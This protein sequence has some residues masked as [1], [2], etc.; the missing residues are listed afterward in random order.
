MKGL[1][2]ANWV[3]CVLRLASYV[4]L[5]VGCFWVVGKFGEMLS[6]KDAIDAEAAKA[7]AVIL[8]LLGTMTLGFVFS[9]VC[10]VL[11]IVFGGLSLLYGINLIMYIVCYRHGIYWKKKAPVIMSLVL[12]ILML[13]LMCLLCFNVGLWAFPVL[14]VP[15]VV[16]GILALKAMNKVGKS[17]HIKLNADGY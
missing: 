4:L 2:K 1:V 14:F 17:G 5:G 7:V 16:L 11:A 10:A 15:D 3:F 6:G 9:L 8:P 13:I 12:G